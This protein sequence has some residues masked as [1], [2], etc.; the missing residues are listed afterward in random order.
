MNYHY[1]VSSEPFATEDQNEL[2]L[3]VSL[4]LADP[5]RAQP[6]RILPASVSGVGARLRSVGQ[7]LH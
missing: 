7:P 3:T 1:Q 6:H 4:S 2:K 5:A